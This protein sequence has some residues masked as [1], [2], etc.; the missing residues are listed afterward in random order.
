MNSY[1]ACLEPLF[2]DSGNDLPQDLLVR[3]PDDSLVH[4]GAK[5]GRHG[6]D[7][8]ALIRAGPGHAQF[9]ERKGRTILLEGLDGLLTCLQFPQHLKDDLP[10]QLFRNLHLSP[11]LVQA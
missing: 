1:Q 3:N 5:S 9:L 11:S 4:H 2:F 8:F 10:D 6:D 7:N